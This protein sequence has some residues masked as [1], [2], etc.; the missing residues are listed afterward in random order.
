MLVEVA[1]RL[2]GVVRACDL[3]SRVGGDEFVVLC[4]DVD[5]VSTS[6][7]LADRMLAAVGEPMRI[8]GIDVA[9]S[10]SIGVATIHGPGRIG[11]VAP[12]T[13]SELLRLADQAMYA[14]KSQPGRGVRLVEIDASPQPSAGDPSTPDRSTPDRSTMTAS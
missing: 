8:E 3:V 11:G 12:V 10:V 5:S 9:V 7:E 2:N 6:R 13:A 14:A 1:S 4:P